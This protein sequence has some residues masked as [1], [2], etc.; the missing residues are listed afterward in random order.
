[1]EPGRDSRDG[2]RTIGQFPGSLEARARIE[3]EL[4]FY[5]DE[6][7][8]LLWADA[9]G[10][11]GNERFGEGINEMLNIMKNHILHGISDGKFFE[12][13][14]PSLRI[15]DSLTH[16]VNRTTGYART[17]WAFG[18]Y[19]MVDALE[20]YIDE[21][22]DT[23]KD[24]LL[25]RVHQAKK[26]IGRDPQIEDDPDILAGRK[27]TKMAIS[28]VMWDRAHD[29]TTNDSARRRFIASSTGERN[30]ERI[31][32]MD[33][34]GLLVVDAIEKK[35]IDREQVIDEAKAVDPSFEFRPD[36]RDLPI[37]TAPLPVM[38]KAKSQLLMMELIWQLD[39]YDLPNVIGN[40]ADLI[41]S[42]G[43]PTGGY[44]RRVIKDYKG[45]K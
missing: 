11:K 30:T 28:L 31:N 35:L 29:G 39:R 15:T 25:E 37:Y 2:R 14:D 45:A 32:A 6:I 10:Q 1:M 42:S 4:S 19:I 24:Q 16:G 38:E 22:H 5:K 20:K 7:S 12:L 44:L 33:W 13:L 17:L 21:Y 41:E 18:P 27:N 36:P 34:M 43:S 26:K 8:P 3:Q 23:L 40:I 9:F